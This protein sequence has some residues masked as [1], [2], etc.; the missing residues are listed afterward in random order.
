MK[1]HTYKGE[2]SVIFERV[3]P[4]GYYLIKL[5]DYQGNLYDKVLCDDYQNAVA[6]RKSFCKIARNFK[7]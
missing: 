1:V 5:Y 3:Y 2:A 6:Y 7:G 4:S